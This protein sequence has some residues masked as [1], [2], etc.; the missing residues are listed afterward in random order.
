[1]PPSSTGRQAGEPARLAAIHSRRNRKGSDGREEVAVTQRFEG[2]AANQTSWWTPCLE[3]YSQTYPITELGLAPERFEAP[4][5]E[6]PHGGEKG[7][8]EPA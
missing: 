3:T 8:S 1:M 4:H 5:R 6:T 2:A 7:V